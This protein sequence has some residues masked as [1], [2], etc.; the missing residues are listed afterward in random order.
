MKPPP[1]RARLQ[2]LLRYD[3]KEK[4]FYW[5]SSSFGAR[6]E[7][8]AGMWAGTKRV[9]TIDGVAYPIYYLIDIYTGGS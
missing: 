9:I 4:Q 8:L 6:K 1:T 3:P 7:K 5:R 2:E